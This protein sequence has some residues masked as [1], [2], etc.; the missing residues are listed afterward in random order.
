MDSIEA[1]LSPQELAGMSAAEFD[2]L[3]YGSIALDKN[4]RVL[5]YN[6]A[7][8]TLA[9]RNVADT[10]GKHFFDEVAPC[11]RTPAFR[12]RLLEL[13]E[14]GKRTARFDYRFRFPWGGRDVRIQLWVS[15]EANWI[16]VLPR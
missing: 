6:A 9:R 14:T 8:A 7:E 16:F 1:V 11:T 10:V 5:R 4:H 13:I 15:D 12:G 3:P 2:A